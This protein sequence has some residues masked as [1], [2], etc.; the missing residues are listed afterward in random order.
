M[1]RVNISFKFISKTIVVMTPFTKSILS[2][3]IHMGYSAYFP[4]EDFN[5]KFKYSVSWKIQTNNHT[6]TSFTYIKS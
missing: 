3:M 2:K 1:E 5:T 4:A 6:N